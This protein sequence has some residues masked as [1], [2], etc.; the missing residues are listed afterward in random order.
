MHVSLGNPFLNSPWVGKEGGSWDRGR[1]NVGAAPVSVLLS[2]GD[3]T[4]GGG[5]EGFRYR[6]LLDI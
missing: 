3:T 4:A 1:Y 6:D 5:G 2:L